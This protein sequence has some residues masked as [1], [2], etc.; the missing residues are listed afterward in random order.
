MGSELLIPETFLPLTLL[1]AMIT[2]LQ[3]VKHLF[4]SP[5]K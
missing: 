2:I 5:L 1:I 4:I 3:T